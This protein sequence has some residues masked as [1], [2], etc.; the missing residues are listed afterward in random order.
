MNAG[1]LE[2]YR[3]KRVLLTGHTGF[4]G[5]WMMRW[6]E[7]LGAEVTGLAL[8]PELE[9]PSHARS[10]GLDVRPSSILGDVRSP[11]TV[12]HAFG[13]TDPEIVFHLAAQALVRRS[14]REP[15]E[16]FA[17]NVMGSAMVLD[18]S[19]SAK[20]LRGV[21]VV[22]TDKV[23]ENQ[24]WVWGYRESDPL[25]GHDP[26]AASKAAAEIVTASYRRSFFAEGRAIATVR[27]GNVIGGGD[28]AEDRIVPD[29]VAALLESRELELRNP[30]AI[31]PW[32]H[33]LDLVNA[34][35]LIGAEILDG[36][37]HAATAWNVGPDAEA[38]IDV[39]DLVNRFSQAWS[40]HPLQTRIRSSQLHEMTLL[41]LDSSLLRARL[42][43]R[44]ILDIQS[45]IGWTAEWY[46]SV[47]V[48]GRSPA[49]ITDQQ[50]DRFSRRMR[51]GDAAP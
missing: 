25:G 1:H 34:Y 8:P 51:T 44:P 24:E 6:L 37:Q 48:S 38:E 30:S 18:A 46:K 17:T 9:R 2:R 45:T 14:Y 3:G 47:N 11:E 19:R 26:Y 7:L 36:R 4:V 21:I 22:T 49:A 33:V 39:Q 28:W 35:L 23:Y 32:Q 16:T 50:I 29:L 31:R 13:T 43:W 5:S 10:L 12:R 40:G 20:N 42:G 41:K 27:G 15:L